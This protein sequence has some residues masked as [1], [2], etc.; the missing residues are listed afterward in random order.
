MQFSPV[1]CLTSKLFAS[2]TSIY[3]KPIQN[4]SKVM[5]VHVEAER[6]YRDNKKTKD[7][8]LEDDRRSFSK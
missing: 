1:C 5:G 3:F 8:E 2:S 4:R 6:L 7:S